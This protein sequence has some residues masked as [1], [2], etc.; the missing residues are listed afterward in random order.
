M[1]AESQ[2]DPKLV[3]LLHSLR[4]R[5]R[6]YIVW[7]SLLALGAVLLVAFWVGLALDYIPV[8]LGGTEMPRSARVVLAIVVGLLCLGVVGKLLL[9]RLLR[10]LPDASLALLVERHH[11]D[12]GGRLVTAV[13]LCRPRRRGDTYAAP[14]LAIV[15]RQAASLTDRVDPRRVFRWEPLIRKGLLVVPLALAAALLGLL[16][17]QTFVQGASRL[18]LFSDDPWPRQ[19][20][21]EMIG[22]EVP[23]AVAAEGADPTA[24]MVTFED[25]FLRLPRGSSGTL[26]IRARAG[27]DAVVPNVCTVYFRSDDGTRGQANMR[28]IG[29]VVDGYQSFI[30]DGAPL[31]GLSESLTL[32]VR[33]LDDRLDD[34]RIEAVEPPAI[35][36]LR[37][38]MRYPDYL[39]QASGQAGGSETDLETDYRSGL[40]IREGSDVTLIA[41]GSQPMREIDLDLRD[42]AGPRTDIDIRYTEDRREAHLRLENVKSATTLRM[43][44]RGEEGISAQAPFRYY[45]G[46]VLDEPPELTVRLTGIGSAVT[47]VAQIPVAAQAADDY[48]IEGLEI[49]AA[50]VGSDAEEAEQEEADAETTA[51]IDASGEE[52]AANGESSDAVTRPLRPDRDGK[53]ETVIDLRDLVADGELPTVRAGQGVHL[54][55]E[56]SDH[57]DL[58]KRPPTRSEVFRLEVVTPEELLALL[59]RRELSFRMRLE[60]T[61]DETRGL[62]DTLD[63][64]RRRWSEESKESK[65][66]VESGAD[67][68]DVDAENSERARVQQV[69]QLRMQQAALQ[70]DKTSE[71]LTGIIASLGDLLEEMINNRV[72]SS[73]RRERIGKGV[74][75]PLQEVVDGSLGRLRQRLEEVQATL[76]QPEEAVAGTAEAVQLAEQVL[77]ELTAVLDKMLDLESYNE[78][79]DLFRGLIDDQEELLEETKQQQ[80]ESVLDLFD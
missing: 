23:M 15:H 30:L 60:Q 5:V 39:R 51:V 25:R 43:V 50:T 28:R 24:E 64:L 27:E 40:R 9:G 2:L 20:E 36:N 68:G 55:G 12:F 70:A 8:Q 29:R 72:D 76:E 80:K 66:S 21:L 4:Q 13:Q 16:S 11:P 33:G 17:P 47:P 69:R 77:I 71:E 26:R 59:E 14:L 63:S 62:R 37:V 49:T 18:A 34:Y 45:L 78:I 54:Y 79:L 1:P 48:G 46:V 3:T 19:A 6:R 61:I 44:P 22:V 31:A 52:S 53:A 7:D 57:Y 74:R 65:E 42:D 73:D 67:S 32:S 41:K 58:S 35:A 10:T 75:D 56:V 38:Q